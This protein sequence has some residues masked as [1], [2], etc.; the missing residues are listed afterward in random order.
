MRYFLERQHGK[1]KETVNR[2]QQRTQ[3]IVTYHL[4][5]MEVSSNC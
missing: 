5:F 4:S 1:I 2:N 3:P